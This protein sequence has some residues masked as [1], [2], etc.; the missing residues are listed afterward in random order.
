MTVAEQDRG[1]GRS[2]ALARD[3]RVLSVAVVG[4]QAAGRAS[5]RPSDADGIEV[6]R[7]AQDRPCRPR[8]PKAISVAA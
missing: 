4:D 7:V 8:L 3:R 5:L 6:E 1:S 2:T